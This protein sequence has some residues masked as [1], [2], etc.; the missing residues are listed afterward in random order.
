MFRNALG[1]IEVVGLAAGIEAADAAV[2][3]ANVDLV[4]YE[5]SKGGGMVV[6][7]IYGDVGAVKAAI[8][9]AAASASRV[10]KV[11]ASHVIP[12]PGEGLERLIANRDTV[13]FSEGQQAKDN[14]S[15]KEDEPGREKAG[16]QESPNQ[17]TAAE[18]DAF[19]KPETLPEQVKEAGGKSE[20]K[21]PNELCNLCKDPVCP[22]RKGDPK[23]TCIHYHKEQEDLEE[24]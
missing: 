15:G 4:G 1:L 24:E 21:R 7:K 9:A 3:A 22:R 23:V 6:I 20:A 14:K 12:R 18:R 16:G 2:K 8:E 13:G 10:S 17:E 5:L 11:V 19:D